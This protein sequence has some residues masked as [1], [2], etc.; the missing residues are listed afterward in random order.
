MAVSAGVGSGPGVNVGRGVFG[1]G[2][3]VGESVETG[4]YWIVS[5]GVAGMGVDVRIG[6]ACSLFNFSTGDS[7]VVCAG[8]ALGT[9]VD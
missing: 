3:G 6:S 9:D 4:V 8:V 1:D 5:T 2:A 7:L